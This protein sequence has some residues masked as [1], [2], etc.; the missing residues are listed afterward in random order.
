M[1]ARLIAERHIVGEHGRFEEQKH[2]VRH[3]LSVENGA[4]RIH[5]PFMTNLPFY[6][7]SVLPAISLESGILHCDIVEGSFRTD[8]FALFIQNLLDYM[9]PF[10]GPNSVIVMDN[11]RIHKNSYIQE[12]IHA[13]YVVIPLVSRSI[14]IDM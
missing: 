11:C 9:E 1:K 7:F 13:R 4:S 12:M 3:F 5:F 14:L 6:S 10:P 2:S 8:S